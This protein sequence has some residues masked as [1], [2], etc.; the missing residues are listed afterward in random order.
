MH[1]ER[2]YFEKL[3]E[4][5]SGKY[6]LK[7]TGIPEKISEWNGK[8]I[9]GFQQDLQQEVKSAISVRWFYNHIKADN[10]EKIPRTDVLDMLCS[11]VGYAGWAEYVSNKK[12]EGLVNTVPTEIKTEVIEEKKTSSK[13]MVVLASLIV[14]VALGWIVFKKPDDKRYSFCFT[15]SDTGT[16]IVKSKIAVT[17]MKDNESPKVIPCDSAGCLVLNSLPGKVKFIVDAQYYRPDTIVRMLP[18]QPSSETIMLKPDDYALMINL[19]SK[20]NVED[21][22]KRRQQ[23]ET[24]FADDAMI[25]Q[26]DP[27]DRKEMDIYN[28]EEFIN[29]L[30]MPLSSL[31]NIEVI[32]TWYK[33]KQISA[34]RFIQK[35]EKH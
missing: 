25:F 27:V 1:P 10:E 14:L 19:F 20:S 17:L 34:L 31:K 7:N 11:Y 3:K 22:D 33:G 6:R 13:V 5:I 8:A 29:K 35:V 2:I 16:P 21:W 12:G 24:M 30:T 4:E 32:Q 28:K 18:E 9:E 23:M 15:D 26:V